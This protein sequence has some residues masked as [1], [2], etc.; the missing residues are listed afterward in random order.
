MVSCISFGQSSKQPYF[1]GFVEEVAGMSFG[2]HSALPNVN[3]A[4]LIRGQDNYTPIEWK[5]EAIPSGYKGKYVTYFWVFAMDVTP[6]PVQFHLSVNNNRWVSFS[7]ATE[8]STGLT[9]H[10]GTDGAELSFK[11]DHA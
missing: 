10:V 6:E 4:L 3:T 1:Q 11:R 8:G 2:Y 7:N 9:T 5:A